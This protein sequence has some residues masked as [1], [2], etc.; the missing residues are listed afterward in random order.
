MYNEQDGIAA[1][2]TELIAAIEG[3]PELDFE[4]LYVNDGSSDRS[5]AILKALSKNDG[6]VQ[7][8]DFA[9]NFDTRSPSPRAST[10]PRATR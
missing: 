4:L 5:L 6:R 9:R 2:H 8:V 1:F 7:V 3:R 10:S